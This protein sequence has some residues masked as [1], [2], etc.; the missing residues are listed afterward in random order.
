MVSSAPKQ[1]A[2]QVDKKKKDS[3]VPV[4]LTYR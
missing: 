3:E 4:T 2:Q 1:F